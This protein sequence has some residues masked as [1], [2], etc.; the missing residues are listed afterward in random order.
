MIRTAR[1]LN[2]RRLRR[3]PL[4][5]V[6]AIV[7]MAA[8]V[9]LGV[10]VIVVGTSIT[11]SLNEFGR[12]LAGPAPLRIIGATSRGGLDSSV[13]GVAERTPGVS[14]AVPVVQAVTM[15][16]SSQVHGL[17]VLG[18]GVDCRVQALIG[19]VGCSDQTLA[20]FTD[21]SPPLVSAWLARRLGPN[22]VVRT[23][24]GRTAVDPTFAV[25]ALDRLNGGRVAVFPLAVAQR[26]FDRQHRLDAVYIIPSRGTS[27][28]QL[29]AR[30]SRAIG[31]W[32]A[33][34][35][36][37]DPPPGIRVVASTV[38]PIFSLL[39]LFALGIGA[40]LIFNI[41]SLTV[42]DRRR[43]LAVV[44]ALGGT[45]RTIVGGTIAEGAALGMVGGLVG[46]AG[47]A[48]LAHPLT[49][50]L[51]DFTKRVIGAAI[52]VHFTANAALAGALLGTVIGAASSW[53]PARRALRM[54]VA[55][56]LSLRDV[57]EEGTRRV[58]AR[59]AGVFSVVGGFGI[60]LCWVA[61]RHGALQPW[62]ASLVPVAVGIALIGCL[63]ALGAY[64]ALMA[65]GAERLLGRSEGSLRLGLNNLV[66]EP[67]RC[68]VMAVAMGAAIT[69]AFVIASS[70]ESIHDGIVHGVAAGNPYEVSVYTVDPNNN[71][72]L[73]TK[74]SPQLLAQL[75]ATPGAVALNPFVALLT[76]HD[77]NHLVGVNAVEHPTLNLPMI[78]G[79]SDPV[80][81][82][83][84]NVLVGPSLARTRHLRVGSHLRLDT[85]TGFAWV[86]VGGVWRNG[87][88]NGNVVDMPMWLLRRLYGNQP[89]TG[90]GL[91]AA[92]DVGPAELAQ[93][94]RT[95]HLDP[96]LQV[97]TP[98][99]LT[100]RF[101]RQISRQLSPFE[102]LQ[103]GLLVVAFIAVLSTLLLVGVQRR[104]EMGL[105]AAIGM[106]P[107]QMARMTVTEG[108][109]V[110]IIGVILGVAGAV[111]MNIAFFFIIPI[112]IGWQDP[113]RFDFF[114]LLLWG[115]I[116]III[117]TAAAVMPAWRNAHLEVLEALQYE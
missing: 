28:G 100:A 7:A 15:A 45:A 86:T 44:G 2:L 19:P 14:S 30:L 93:R 36:A 10:S 104:R 60:A 76:G 105:L 5:V 41:M 71:V 96:D 6:L 33:V 17:T 75:S 20:Q 50:T 27:T 37:S 109:A 87:N 56:E 80:R 74:A 4:R 106:E 84:G 31:G 83:Q 23:D 107:S 94:V 90:V 112:L 95:A 52:T 61:Q 115:P 38:I 114:S 46:S 48:L 24:V 81:F 88:F 54:D 116:G 68:G 91:I 40:L 25:P 13:L 55:A 51:S 64:A 29:R 1:L 78:L 57:R 18:F 98:A 35:G 89:S 26:V 79:S 42:E 32:N 34:L 43:D 108:I 117:V 70:H 11:R 97:D 63:L 85:P 111:V 22:G 16:E 72:N 62:Q 66:R 102:A 58:S 65:Q 67:R 9:S 69:T 82:D 3:Q 73:D 101:T 8:G 49:V 21:T 59:R 92:R 47:G 113:L 12:R 39:A 103:R 53:M 77:D 99:Q 110:G